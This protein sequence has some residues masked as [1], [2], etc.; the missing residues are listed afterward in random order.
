MRC[1]TAARSRATR[2]RWRVNAR[3]GQPAVPS[4]CFVPGPCDGPE[5]IRAAVFAAGG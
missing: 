2:C 1:A 3:L 5:C 4:V